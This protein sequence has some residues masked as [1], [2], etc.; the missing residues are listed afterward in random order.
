MGWTWGAT[1]WRST[2]GGAFAKILPSPDGQ[3]SDPTT[4][5]LL[6]AVALGGK[7]YAT[8]GV[9]VFTHDGSAFGPFVDLASMTWPLTFRERIVFTALQKVWTFDGGMPAD[10]GITPSLTTMGLALPVYAADGEHFVVVNAVGEVLHTTDLVS[11]DCVGRAPPGVTAIGLLDGRIYFGSRDASIW[12][13]DR[14]AW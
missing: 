2:G 10:T 11:W 4:F 13:F 12:S 8:T 9:R 7:V 1:I 3:T 5:A 14:V 6:S